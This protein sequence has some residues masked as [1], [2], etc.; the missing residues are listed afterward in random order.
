MD[1]RNSSRKCA[2]CGHIAKENR[3]NQSTFRC[4]ACS[5]AAHG[6]TN[7][8]RVIGV[9]PPVNWLRATAPDFA[10]VLLFCMVSEKSLPSGVRSFTA[11]FSG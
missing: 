9:E 10:T 4:V 5:H 7:A 3:P 11:L 1:P 8:A 2:E 6:D